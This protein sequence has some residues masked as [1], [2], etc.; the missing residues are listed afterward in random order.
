M[1]VCVAAYQCIVRCPMHRWSTPRAAAVERSNPASK[2]EQPR[3]LVI[4]D[5]LGDGAGAYGI[6]QLIAPRSRGPGH[7]QVQSCER[8]RLRRPVAIQSETTTPW[9][10]HSSLSTSRS[11]GAIGGHGVSVDRVVRS[12]HHRHVGLEDARFKR[13]QVHLAQHL[14]GDP[15]IVRAP[16]GLGVIGD[17]VLGG[18]PD[19]RLLHDHARTPRRCAWSATGPPRSTRSLVRRAGS[20]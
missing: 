18:R 15:R 17:I 8:G 3:D 10:P 19:S 12:H 7:D 14:L 4:D 16:I 11:S 2:S 20:E 6:E 1:S 9:N 5:S 13:R